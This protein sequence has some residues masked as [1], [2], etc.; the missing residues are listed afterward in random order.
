M[1]AVLKT[2]SLRDSP[3]TDG[4]VAGPPL[5]GGVAPTSRAKFL[6]TPREALCPCAITG[7]VVS[8]QETGVVSPE[9]P[10][11]CRQMQGF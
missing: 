11:W 10:E 3:G 6:D 1:V 4:A 9:V 2:G 8:A 7:V 5:A